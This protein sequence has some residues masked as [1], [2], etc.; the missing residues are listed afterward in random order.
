LP[1]DVFTPEPLIE[2]PKSQPREEPSESDDD[3]QT[4]SEHQLRLLNKKPVA[5]TAPVEDLPAPKLQLNNEIDKFLGID[6][7]EFGYSDE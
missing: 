3:E 2:T 7:K 4:L 1:D 5:N 6:V